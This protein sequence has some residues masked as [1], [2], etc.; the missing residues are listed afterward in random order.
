MVAGNMNL[1]SA[2]SICRNRGSGFTNPIVNPSHGIDLYQSSSNKSVPLLSPTSTNQFTQLSNSPIMTTPPIVYF[3]DRDPEIFRFVLDYYRTGEL[4]LPSSICGPFVRKEL[5]FWGIDEA[6][7]GPCCMPAYMRYDEEKRTKNTL[8]R[9][10]FEDIDSMQN[11]VKFSRGW[12]KWRYRMWL[13]MDHPSSSL[14]AKR[15][16]VKRTERASL[17]FDKD[18]I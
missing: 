5:I 14:A 16:T 6:L 10:C 3:Y 7:I 13:F 2:S 15:I 9:D 11:L 1:Q 12:K 18:F 8:F 17:E 4:H